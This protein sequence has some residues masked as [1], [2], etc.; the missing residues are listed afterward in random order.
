MA[1]SLFDSRSL[2][3]AINLLKTPESFVIDRI[4][5]T[6]EMHSEDTI[7]Y[8]VISGGGKV[9][10]Y[11]NKHDIQPK[12]VVNLS[13]AAKSI[14]IPRT[15]ESKVFTAKDLRDINTIGNVYSSEPAK[16]AAQKTRILQELAE[17]KNRVI[18]R[19]ELLGCVGLDTGAISVSQDDISFSIDWN[20][21][22]DTHK[23]TYTG[24][25]LWTNEAST[26][27]TQLLAWRKDISKRSG[28]NANILLLG[29]TAASAFINHADIKS[30]LDANNF[31]MG[32]IDLNSQPTAGVTYYGRIFGIDIYEYHQ[33]Y[34]N[35]SDV[36]TDMITATSAV[37]VA[38]SNR[39]KLH[40][41]S[42]YRIDSGV[43]KAV[44]VEYLLEIDKSSNDQF[45]QWNL[46]A[47][48]LPTIHDP[49]CVI[50]AKVA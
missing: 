16:Q 27:L 44:T 30:Y 42:P 48:S 15:F 49:G 34:V 31:R 1:I 2:T 6:V 10:Q 14:I 3:Q 32:T 25:D 35:S 38:P 47:K 28:F 11:A 19:R 12:P 4:F 37:L 21:V 29:S 50:T 9:A 22:A 20:F 26:P 39:F 13:N 36:A 45:L 43:A 17:L 24:T 33:T 8:E 23:L 7:D 46:E 40:I 41:G 5:S 18:L